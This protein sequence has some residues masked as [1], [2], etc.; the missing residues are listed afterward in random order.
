MYTKVYIILLLVKLHNV[1]E[2][3]GLDFRS[4][5]GSEQIFVNKFCAINYNCMY[6]ATVYKNIL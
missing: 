6:N 5:I 4:D 1:L 3:V 2:A